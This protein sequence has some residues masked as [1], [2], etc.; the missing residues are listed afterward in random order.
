M[1]RRGKGDLPSKSRKEG[2][3]VEAYRY[4][5]VVQDTLLCWY[6]SEVDEVCSR[7]DDIVGLQT[8]VHLITYS[9]S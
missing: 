6:K 8:T 5:V 9:Q 1:M 7:P 3:E 2:K 4:T